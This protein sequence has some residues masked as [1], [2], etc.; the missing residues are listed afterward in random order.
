MIA[1]GTNEFQP[2]WADDAGEALAR[3]C[4][5]D[6]LAGQALD[7]AGAERT[8]MRDLLDRFARLTGREP[9]RVPVPGVVA[10]LGVKLADA[11][12]VDL[13]INE[14]QLTMV[15]EGNLIEDPAANAL[16][17]VL[18]WR[19]RRSTTGCG[20][21]STRFPSSSPRRGSAP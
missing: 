1:G 4:E 5:R 9:L 7:V 13:G 14:S 20:G 3:A 17:R 6:D 21:C 10:S 16:E 8:S 15:A 11:V 12:G 19:R 18:A 2:I